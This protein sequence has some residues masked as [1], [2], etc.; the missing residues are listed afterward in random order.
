MSID[1]PLRVQ[2]D[3]YVGGPATVHGPVQARSLTVG[4]PLTT[5]LPKDGPPGPAGQA[6]ATPLSIG[7]PLTVNGPLI[8]DGSL[9][10]GGPLKC[11]SAPQLLGDTPLA[12][13]GGSR[14]D[15]MLPPHQA[16]QDQW[17]E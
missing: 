1:G 15:P 7:G 13:Q 10:V 3:L 4:G 9:V 5:T 11:E 8:V 14:Q 12:G 2:G 17:T 6:Y 16:S